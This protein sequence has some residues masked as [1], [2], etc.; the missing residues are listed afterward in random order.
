[1]E[2]SHFVQNTSHMYE[3]NSASKAIVGPNG[4]PYYP[5]RNSVVCYNCGEEGDVRPHCPKMRSQGPSSMSAGQDVVRPDIRCSDDI[6]PP[7]PPAPSVRGSGQ[8]VSVMEIAMKSSALEGVKVREV[9]AT[10]TEETVDVRQ[11]VNHV[12]EV[13]RGDHLESDGTDELFED[14]DDVVPVMAGE[15]ARRFSE[16]PPEFDCEPRPARQRRRTTYTAEDEEGE[17]ETPGRPKA[18]AKP[19]APRKPIWMMAGREKFDFVG[20]FRDS[21]ITGL[22]WGS[23]FDLAPSVKQ[24]ICYQ[25]VQELTRKKGKGQGKGKK[26]TIEEV[27][28]KQEVSA[29]ITDRNL[30]DVINF[31]TKGIVTTEKGE[32]RVLRILVEAGSVVNLLPI[33][34][35]EY[36]GAKL[37]NAGGMVIRTAT[38]AD[39]K[40]V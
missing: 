5:G 2:S 4:G 15:R 18:K 34:L 38:N 30:G 27:P 36:T 39:A 8:N 33:H 17:E 22:N 29:V 28:D 19:T 10:T 1:M 16:L 13:D 24:D 9:T 25:L 3:G 26:V 14:D 32:F 31:Y 23:F 20:A 7:L 37:C 35:L 11:F 12:E 40:I 6:L 21:P